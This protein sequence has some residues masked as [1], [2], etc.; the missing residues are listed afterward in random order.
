[1]FIQQLK[2]QDSSTGDEF[3]IEVNRWLS[4]S[5]DDGDIWREFAISQIGKILPGKKI[6]LGVLCIAIMASI[7]HST[8]L[9]LSVVLM[10]ALVTVVTYTVEVHTGGTEGANTTASVFICIYGTRGD[11]GKRK[12]FKSQTSN[13]PFQK[14]AVSA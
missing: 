9:W 11:T 4:R 14:G 7:G 1:M 12:L 5:H 6:F 10:V 2:L 13:D 8:L 3:D